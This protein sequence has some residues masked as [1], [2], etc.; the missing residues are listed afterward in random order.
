MSVGKG[1][2][3]SSLSASSSASAS[4]SVSYRR[5]PS[6]P[7]NSPPNVY[8]IHQS[9]ALHHQ[10]HPS[11]SASG[12]SGSSSSHHYSQSYPSA[13][14]P[15]SGG[16]G[17]S[18]STGPSAYVQPQPQQPQPQHYRSTTSPSSIRTGA[19][20]TFSY[21][22]PLSPSPLQ[23]EFSTGST[24]TGESVAESFVT[25]TD[26]TSD[27]GVGVGGHAVNVQISAAEEPSSGA[28]AATPA[29]VD[30]EEGETQKTE[31][32]D[33]DLDVKDLVM[34][35]KSEKEESS[36]S[37]HHHEQDA[38]NDGL[39]ASSPPTQ[40]APLRAPTP[41]PTPSPLDILTDHYINAYSPAELKTFHCEKVRKMPLSGLDPSMLIGFLVKDEADWRD[42]RRRVSEVSVLI[43]FYLRLSGRWG[44]YMRLFLP[45]SL[46]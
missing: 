34:N 5:S 14:V 43:R 13:S 16:A 19:S 26:G 22:A 39:P 15:I 44:A 23:K 24:T 8:S 4:P 27:S 42:F 20:S 10:Q 21:H 25:G 12:S 36:S 6:P 45:L 28:A 17:V 11:A 41:P 1:R 46:W 35:P 9:L 30:E 33:E 7:S 40:A 32:Q 2:P 3:P 38:S 31:E 29:T 18:A 37:S